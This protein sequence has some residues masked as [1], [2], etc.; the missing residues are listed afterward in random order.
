MTIATSARTTVNLTFRAHAAL[1][2]TMAR[3]RMSKTDIVNRAVTLYEIIDSEAS[4]G[5][6]IV[7]RRDGQ[8]R[9]VMLL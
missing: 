4:T 5:A 6:E 3:T 2:A 7:I 8:E 9:A 1:K